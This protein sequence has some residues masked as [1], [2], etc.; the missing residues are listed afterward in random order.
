V[1]L[2]DAIVVCIANIDWRENW[3][4]QQEVATAFGAAGHRV[5]FVENTGVRRPEWKD[6]PRLASRLRNWRGSGG[7]VHREAAGVDIYSP[8]LV[9][10]PY[11]RLACRFNRT[12]M[13]HRIRRW[14]GRVA[15]TFV[16]ITFLPTPLV[17]GVIDALN[18]ALVVYYAVDALSESSPGARPLREHEEALFRDADVVF[19]TSDALR[20][21]ALELGAKPEMLAHGVRAQEFLRVR[22]ARGESPELLDHLTGPVS[23]YV[24]S[25]RREIDLALVAEAAKRAA[26]LQFVFVGPVSTDVGAFDALPNVHFIAPV[27]HPDVMRYMARFDA[28]I[29]P[30]VHNAYTAHIMPAKLKEY[31]AAGLP[32]VATRLPEIVRFAELHGGLIEFADDADSFVAAL[33][34]TMVAHA[35]R[36]LELR[37]E[38]A[39]QYDWATQMDAMRSTM[40]AALRARAGRR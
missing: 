18:P 36:D 29:L 12:A 11:S 35:P 6:L 9:P 25:V 22:R 31:L 23:G 40:D 1:K 2:D 16:V 15:R 14:I 4:S 24:G 37:A 7:G 8:V 27:P 20:S 33:R 3:Q 5:L 28:G 39:R 30:Y 21:F 19:T 34:R 26:D 38:V 10:L 32:I 17:R 13:L